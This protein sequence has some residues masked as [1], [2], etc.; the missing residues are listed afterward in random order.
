MKPGFLLFILIP[1]LEIVVLLIS[2]KLIGIGWTIAMLFITAIIGVFLAKRQGAQTINKLRQQL[3][4]GE[5]PGEEL[6]NGICILI[7]GLFLLLPGFISDLIGLTLLIPITR[8]VYKPLIY[9]WIRK[10]MK[11]PSKNITIIR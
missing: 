10:Y 7:G 5:M 6:Y 9:L 4:R 3:S 2:G 8:K 1:V 11:K